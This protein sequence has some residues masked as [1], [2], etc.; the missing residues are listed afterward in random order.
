M[1]KKRFRAEQIIRVLSE[2]KVEVA[3]GQVSSPGL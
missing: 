1:G 3:R 2:A